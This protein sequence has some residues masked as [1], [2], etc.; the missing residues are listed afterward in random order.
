ML[1]QEQ[2][3]ILEQAIFLLFRLRDEQSQENWEEKRTRDIARRLKYEEEKKQE[4]KDTYDN[5]IKKAFLKINKELK[6]MPTKIRDIFDQQWLEKHLRQKT[7]GIYEI[8]CSINKVPISAS[9]K[10]INSAAEDFIRKLIDLEQGIKKDLE[11]EK[12]QFN[13]FA[14]KWFVV[15]KKPTVKPNTYEA[16]YAS[17]TTHIKPYFHNTPIKSI[18]PMEIQPLFTKFIKAKTP[19]AAQ[20]VKVLLNQI[21][22]SAVAE[23]LI[24]RN[25]MDGVQLM[26]YQ[27][28]KGKSLTIEEEREF[29]LNIQGSR[30]E[31][32]FIF[33][34][35]GGMRR[36]ELCSVR[37]EGGFLIVKDGKIRAGLEQTERRVPITPMLSRYLNNATKMQIKV[38]L[39]Y[40]VEMLT[41]YFKLFCPAHHLHELRHTYITRCQECGVPREVV[42]VWAGHAA[43]KTMTSTVYTHFSDDFMISEGKKVDYYNRL[44]G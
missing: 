44:K 11:E 33:L 6:K 1:N 20:I 4:E 25:P 40:N 30:Y 9:G 23:R 3:Q 16:F 29:L 32:A 22:R 10:T 12:T 31:L 37:I 42:S 36:G 28:R 26:K 14:E 39:S 15:V 2:T 5:S 13:D 8:R 21:F 43:D 41:R 17:Y 19:K 35:F 24:E 27:P 38:A 18:T 34:L 7:N